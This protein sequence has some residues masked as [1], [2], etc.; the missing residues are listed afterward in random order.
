MIQLVELFEHGPFDQHTG[1][2]DQKG[3]NQQCKP[4][5]DAQVG[6]TKPGN[7]GAQHVLSAVG[8]IDDVEQ[9]KD[10]RQAQ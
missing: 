6:H 9:P 4:I 2:T 1:C 10:H 7:E 3:R 5:I 8:E